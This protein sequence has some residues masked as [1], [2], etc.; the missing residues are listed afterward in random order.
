MELQIP[1]S[2]QAAFE[3]KAH[4]YYMYE[5]LMSTPEGLQLVLEEKSRSMIHSAAAALSTKNMVYWVGNGTSY[6]NAMF[7]S[8]VFNTPGGKLSIAQPAYE[9]FAYPPNGIDENTAV[10]GVSHSGTSPAAVDALEM[11]KKRDALTVGIS[12]YA[13]SALLNVADYGICSENK[14]INGPKTRS[15]VAS[16]LRA[17]MLAIELA[18]KQGLDLSGL[19]ASLTQVPAITRQVL[20][21]NEQVVKKFAEGRVSKPNN[22]LVFAAAGPAFATAME[23]TLKVVETMLLH[24]S[25]WELEE[26]VHGTWVSQK[27]GELLVIFAPRGASFEKCK[28]LVRGMKTVNANVW[29]ITDEQ[30][31]M[32]GADFTTILPDSVNE[33]TFPLYAILPVYQFIYF[34]TLAQGNL[35]P[36]RAPYEDP[37]FMQAR[38]ELRTWR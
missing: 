5:S 11:A 22:R 10:I 31:G 12:D 6:F 29:V 37:R 25:A 15:Y 30:K 19:Q 17:L 13:G 7:G 27:E 2:M 36:D 9:F 38:F 20:K 32:D 28:I 8:Y 26:A 35:H 21:E 4:P 1:Q 23:A 34:H 16:D 14:E 24:A 33:L 18:G 3:R